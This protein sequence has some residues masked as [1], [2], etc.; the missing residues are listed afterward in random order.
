MQTDYTISVVKEDPPTSFLEN[1]FLKCCVTQLHT[2]FDSRCFVYCLH[3]CKLGS[4]S[5]FDYHKEDFVFDRSEKSLAKHRNRFSR[6][7]EDVSSDV[8][9]LNDQG[10]LFKRA[11]RDPPS[12]NGP[13]MEAQEQPIIAPRRRLEPSFCST[14]WGCGAVEED[15]NEDCLPDCEESDIFHRTLECLTECFDK[16]CFLNGKFNH[17]S[18]QSLSQTLFSQNSDRT[19]HEKDLFNVQRQVSF[20]HH[21]EGI[22]SVGIVQESDGHVEQPHQSNYLIRIR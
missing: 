17:S 6:Y 7:V 16:F 21:K 5:W 10:K 3:C 8:D 13:H 12:Q 19:F 15:L 14:Q 4:P 22:C 18:F 9:L 2:L 20:V 11:R 1:G